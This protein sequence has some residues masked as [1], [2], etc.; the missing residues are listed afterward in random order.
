MTSILRRTVRNRRTS[1]KINSK[2]SREKVSIRAVIKLHNRNIV[3]PIKINNDTIERARPS[4]IVNLLPFFVKSQIFIE[5]SPMIR[6]TRKQKRNI[7]K[8]PIANCWSAFG[9]ERP[10]KATFISTIK[11]KIA[12]KKN[13][14]PETKYNHSNFLIIFGFSS[15]LYFLYEKYYLAGIN[16]FGGKMGEY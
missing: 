13:I 7:D 1:S 6:H 15:I 4:S 10:D 5:K 11:A 14:P 16:F 2:V 12:S 3:G 8:H 9:S